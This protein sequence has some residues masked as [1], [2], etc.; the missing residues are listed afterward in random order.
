MIKLLNGATQLHYVVGDPIDQV[1]SPEG[2]TETLQQKGL[3]AICV[4]AHVTSQ[5]L[6]AFYQSCRITE[7]VN[8]VI[9]TVPHKIQSV[10]FCDKLSQRSKFLGSVNVLRITE[11]GFEGDMLDGIGYIL[12]LQ[13]KGCNIK[14][15]RV[16]LC[17]LGGAGRAIAHA[18]TTNG[19]GELAVF[20]VDEQR[21]NDMIKRLNNLNQGKVI[22]GSRNLQG[23]DIAINATPTGMNETDALPFDIDTFPEGLWAGDVVT[24]P[25]ETRWIKAA[26]DRGSNVVIGMDMFSKVRDLMIDFIVEGKAPA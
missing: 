1:K 7:N 2:V 26:K 19:V 13:E 14:G 4:P 9:V 15:K 11:N 3:N 22:K 10:R 23:F 24:K 17:G 18:L 21:Q 20:D 12:A 5:N 6:A 8:S 25:V 16:L